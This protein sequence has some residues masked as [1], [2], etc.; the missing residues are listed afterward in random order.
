MTD[1]E[2]PMVTWGTWSNWSNGRIQIQHEQSS[3]DFSNLATFVAAG[4]HLVMWIAVCYGKPLEIGKTWQNIHKMMHHFPLVSFIYWAHSDTIFWKI[5]KAAIP[6]NLNGSFDEFAAGLPSQPNAVTLVS[7]SKTN[8]S[9][10]WTVPDNNGAD[11]YQSG[12]LVL[13]RSSGE[14]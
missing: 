7:Q 2:I 3:S 5:G 9:V 1:I 13:G 4:G 8:I 11:I 10:S 14:A 6:V 12:L